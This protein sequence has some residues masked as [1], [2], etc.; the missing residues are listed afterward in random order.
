MTLAVEN[1]PIYLFSKSP[2]L[3]L[4]GSFRNILRIIVGAEKLIRKK[5]NKTFDL[6]RVS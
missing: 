4:T 3:Q 5:N 2:S 6:D 1:T